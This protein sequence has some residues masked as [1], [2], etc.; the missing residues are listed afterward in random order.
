MV[1]SLFCVR[2]G[3]PASCYNGVAMTTLHVSAPGRICLFGEHQ[4]YL[5]LPVIAAAVSL[6]IGVHASP[7][8]DGLFAIE[9]PDLGERVVLDA[10]WEQLYTAPRDYIRS[11]MNVL[12]RKGMRWPQG[13][14]VI[15][16][17]AIPMNAG[18]SSSSA[19]VVMWLRFLLEVGMN[20]PAFDDSQL[21]RWAYEA[22][23]LEF[24]E[25]GGMMD[26][27]CASLGGL[28]WIDTVPPFAA[29][30]WENSLEGIVVGN[31]REPKAT[32]ETLA[33]NRRD[34]TEGAAK[35][36]DR[37]AAFDLAT[38]PLAEVDH[39]IRALPPDP[40]RRLRANMVNR[41]ITLEAREAIV[42]GDQLRVGHLLTLHHAQLRDGL[43]LSTEKIERMIDSSLNAGALG[44]KVNG[45]G[46]GGCMF[47][48]APGRE[49]EVAEAIRSEGGVPYIVTVDDG[50]RVGE[51]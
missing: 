27:F 35:L 2:S 34:V 15:L 26:H 37:F 46:G 31:S 22:E 21:A 9:M 7:R 33:R 17:G 13:Y 20:A 39:R 48:Y 45:S 32:L 40:G 42:Q 10:S 49:K 19:L 1:C 41:N 38:S 51:W 25:P 8:Q 47:A 36:R 18:V 12:Y 44:A 16:H 5:G 4:D 23:V 29:E 6:R 24:R 3:V 28:L 43:D 14:D 30:R 11:C 50:V